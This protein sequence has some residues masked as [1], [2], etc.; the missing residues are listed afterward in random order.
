C[1]LGSEQPE[2]CIK[3]IQLMVA[4]DNGFRNEFD[5]IIEF[6]MALD[7]QP[8][9]PDL[10]ELYKVHP[11]GDFIVEWYYNEESVSVVLQELKKK[12]T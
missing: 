3:S 7:M 6:A 9:D 2:K 10:H 1:L 8:M 12:Q 4:S 5:Q 11:R